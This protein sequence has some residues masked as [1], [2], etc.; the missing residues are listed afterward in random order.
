[1]RS[2]VGERELKVGCDGMGMETEMEMEMEMGL[3]GDIDDY[4]EV[5]GGR[6][7]LRRGRPNELKTMRT[8]MAVSAC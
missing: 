2:V 8:T 3:L 7:R 5:S 6:V 4:G 1:M